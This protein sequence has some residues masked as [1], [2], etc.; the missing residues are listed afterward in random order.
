VG[1]DPIALL[2]RQVPEDFDKRNVL[3]K[4]FVYGKKLYIAKVVYR[5]WFSGNRF[6]R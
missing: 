3:K 2:S 4:G 6:L 5:L 1:R